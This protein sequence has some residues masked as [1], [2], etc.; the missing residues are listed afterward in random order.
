MKNEHRRSERF[1]DIGRVEAHQICALP[2]VLDDISLTGCKVHFPIPVT[3]DMDSDIDLKI[4]LSTK[5]SKGHLTLLCHPQ[6]VNKKGSET[7]V[8]FSIMRSPDTRELHSHINL[9]KENAADA[10]DVSSLIISPAVTYI[11]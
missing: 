3:V 10:D 8:G 1:D 6:W 11:S 9:L 2:G 7:E 4:K 5:V